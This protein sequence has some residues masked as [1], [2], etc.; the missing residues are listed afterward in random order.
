MKALSHRRAIANSIASRQ[1]VPTAQ[2]GVDALWTGIVAKLNAA[3]PKT[4]EPVAAGR[5]AAPGS[6]KPT[7]ASVDS[8]WAGLARNL[9]NEAGLVTPARR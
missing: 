2:A 7:Q 4:Q 5:T 3:L 9:N 6:A 8:M 1:G